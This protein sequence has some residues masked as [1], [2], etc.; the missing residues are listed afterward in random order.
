MPKLSDLKNYDP[1][2]LTVEECMATDLFTVQ[3]D[4]IIDFVAH[5]MDWRKVRYLP[6]EDSEGELVGLVT[7]RL[8]LRHYANKHEGKKPDTVKEIMIKNPI[9]ITQD[10]RLLDAM[11]VMRQENIGCLPV[12]KGKELVGLVTEMTVLRL[13]VRLLE[14]LENE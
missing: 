8:L 14:R 6:V 4:D 10:M 1:G 2:K 7:S 12:V 3:K 11:R 13:S 9:T 5:L